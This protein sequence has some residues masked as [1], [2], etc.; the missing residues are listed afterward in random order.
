MIVD[1][2]CQGCGVLF[3]T[4]SWR[5]GRFHDRICAGNAGRKARAFKM[6]ATFASRFWARV[7]KTGTCWLW[8]GSPTSSGYG[9][10]KCGERGLQQAHRI[11][12]ELTH[13]EIPEDKKVLHKCDV[14]LCV[15]PDHPDHL[16]LGTQQDN[17]DDM[18]SKGRASRLAGEESPRSKLSK[19]DVIK[20]RAALTDGA[21]AEDL[22]KSFDV[23]SSTISLIKNKKIWNSEA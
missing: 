12:W 1:R 3:K 19:V 16:F 21:L 10:L 20:I 15:R 14:R 9:K 6:D 8:K 17:M 4:Q 2:T 18:V 23:S 11:A 22:A 5:V 7:E 13:G